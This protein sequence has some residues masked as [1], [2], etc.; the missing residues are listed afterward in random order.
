MRFAE[1]RPLS[2]TSASLPKAV[3]DANATAMMDEIIVIRATR[4]HLILAR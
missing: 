4:H 1:T 3:V 2:G